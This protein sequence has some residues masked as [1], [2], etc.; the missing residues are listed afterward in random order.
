GYYTIEAYF[1]NLSGQGKFDISVLE[2]GIGEPWSSATAKELT[3]DN[4]QLYGSADELITLGADVGAFVPNEGSDGGYF[5]AE[6]VDSGMMNTTIKLSG[7]DVE[8]IDQDGSETLIDIELGNIPAGFTVTDGTHTFTGSQG[9][10]SVSI[11]DWDLDN[12]SLIPTQDY[13]GTVN[14][15]VSATTKEAS[16]GDTKTSS[17]DLPVEVVDFDGA[18]KGLDPD[19]KNTDGLF[20]NGTDG[21]DVMYATN[22]VATVNGETGGSQNGWAINF[23]S[24]KPGLSITKVVIDLNN[25]ANGDVHFSAGS[26][27]FNYK[28]Q[29]TFKLNSPSHQSINGSALVKSYGISDFQGGLLYKTP[30]KLTINFKD[31]AFTEGKEFNFAADTDTNTSPNHSYADQLAGS[32]ITIYFSDGSSQTVTYINQGTGSGANSTSEASFAEHYLNGG[33]GDDTIYGSSGDDYLVGGNGNDYLEGGAG[34]D[35]L[36][37]GAGDD[38]LHGGAGN[39]RLVGGAGNDELYGGKGDDIL[40]GGAGNDL[41]VGGAGNDILTGGLGT[42]VFKWTLNNA[43]NGSGDHD[44]ITDFSHAQGDLIDLQDLLQGENAGNIENYLSFEKS[45]NDTIINVS[46]DGNGEVTQTITVQNVDFTA[47]GS[48]DKEIIEHLL[49]NNYLKVDQ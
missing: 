37:G 7:I 47:F 29:S 22:V 23:D 11:M 5:S 14:L 12:L 6:A 46:Y 39:D 43:E 10:N 19:I 35:Y 40:E 33:D 45:G 15:T 17:I 20:I 16:N 18:T 2:K 34:N 44:V 30:Q 4:Y 13:S 3:S 36:S 24:G 38:K 32:T 31:G 8:L 25:S 42:D 41:L 26:S 48:T 9:Q 28:N 21:N 49:N 1:A 27:S